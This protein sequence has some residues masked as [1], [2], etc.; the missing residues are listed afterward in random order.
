MIENMQEREENEMDERYLTKDNMCR[1]PAEVLPDYM[2]GGANRVSVP[3]LPV[4][5]RDLKVFYGGGFNQ[6]LDTALEK[7]LS[8]F[9]YDRWA[10]G[11]ELDAGLRDLA[12][13]KRLLEGHHGNL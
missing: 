13:D 10:S 9:G 2:T 7:T 5:D 6:E 12:F 11:M 8:E 4:A 1:N 3:S